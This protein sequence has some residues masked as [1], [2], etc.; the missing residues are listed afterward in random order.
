MAGITISPDSGTQFEAG[1]AEYNSI[2]RLDDDHYVIAYRDNNDYNKGKVN[3][4]SRTGTSVTISEANAV[5]FNND[6]TDT[7][8]IRS[9]SASLIVISYR[10]VNSGLGYVI[11][12]TVSGT[13]VTLGSAVSVWAGAAITANKITVAEL[14]STDFVV[15]E[16]YGSSILSFVG[17]VS[18]TTITLGSGQT[19]FSA[20]D[21]AIMNSTG[22]NGTHYVTVYGNTGNPGCIYA[23]VG[24]VDVGAKTITFG[25]ISGAIGGYANWYTEVLL[26]SA[27]DSQHFIVASTEPDYGGYYKNLFLQA[28]SVNLSTHAITIGSQIDSHNG[29]S[30]LTLSNYSLCAVNGYSFLIS[31]YTTT[32]TQGE[33]RSGTLSG[34]TTIAWDAQGAQVFD[35]DTSAHTALCR[36][37]DDY[38]ILGYKSG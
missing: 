23:R 21:A 25:T 5:I 38:F 10:D 26:I 19:V 35:N 7:I 4:G 28:C 15:T 2:A 1:A 30:N 37:T 18:G 31:Y 34:D 14:D 16:S 33:I 3:V 27:F 32:G 8:I 12:G 22:L 24:E 13:T 6:D 9:L 11:A 36:L 17:S 29:V 20:I